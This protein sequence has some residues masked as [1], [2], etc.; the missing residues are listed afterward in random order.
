MLEKVAE[1]SGKEMVEEQGFTGIRFEEPNEGGAFVGRGHLVIGVGAG[2][3][4]SVLATLRNPPAAQVSLTGSAILARAN[5]LLPPV[6]GLAYHLTDM[7]RYVK[8]TRRV[9]NSLL[10]MTLKTQDEGDPDDADLTSMLR[11]LQKLLPSEDELRACSAW[12]LA[13]W[14]SARRVS[15]AVA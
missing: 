15:P 7:N 2:L 11:T 10:N 14:S 6:D 13:R 3:T 5:E 1:A 12:K 8:T 9:F 4:E